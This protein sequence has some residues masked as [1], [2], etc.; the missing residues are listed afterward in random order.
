VQGANDPTG[1]PRTRS[2]E[3]EPDTSV[4]RQRFQLRDRHELEDFRAWLFTYASGH[5]SLADDAQKA[6]VAAAELIDN[7]LRH[8]Q[9]E[10]PVA[11]VQVVFEGGDDGQE[12][13]TITV[14]DGGDGFASLGL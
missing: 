10:A 8:G 14:A 7:A 11:D 12:S 3:P 6:N 1:A 4:E 13:L 2:A 9:P 5:G